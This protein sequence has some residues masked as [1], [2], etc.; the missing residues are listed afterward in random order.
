LEPEIIEHYINRKTT[1]MS[2]DTTAS[3][4]EINYVVY[5]PFSEFKTIYMNV[6]QNG[7]VIGTYNLEMA[8]TKHKLNGLR[9]NSSYRLDFYYTYDDENNFTQNVLFDSVL[10]QTKNI[11]GNITLEKVSNNSVRYIL[12]ID[13]DY[14]LDSA[15][16]AM[17]IDGVLVAKDAVNGKD[18]A[19][20][21]GFISTITYEGIGDFVVLK[22]EDC[23]YNGAQVAIDASY[24]Y[25]L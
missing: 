11:N 20:K 6:L 10:V 13:G 1:I 5:D 17:Y 8:L 14:K 3:S 7:V 12:K 21:D 2:V 9:A 25:K 16:V 24:K 23:I 15:N 22:L 4:A 19:S 18:A